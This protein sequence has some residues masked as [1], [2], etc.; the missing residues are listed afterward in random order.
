MQN[1]STTTGNVQVSVWSDSKLLETK[2]S[3]VP[4]HY[5]GR[6]TL[7]SLR[8]VCHICAGIAERNKGV[9]PMAIARALRAAAAALVE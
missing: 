1:M 5:K 9:V 8:N 2:W 3:E 4:E 6:L 7:L